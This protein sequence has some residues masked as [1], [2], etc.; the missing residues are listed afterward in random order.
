MVVVMFHF[1][2]VALPQFDALKC[3][4]PKI[5]MFSMEITSLTTQYAC[6]NVSNYL[7]CINLIRGIG[8]FY[9]QNYTCFHRK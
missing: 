4:M 3:F 2:F 1:T 9:T 7:R 6:C 8:E 5:V